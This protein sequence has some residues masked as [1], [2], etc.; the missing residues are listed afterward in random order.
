MMDMIEEE[1]VMYLLSMLDGMI[2]DEE[3]A[4]KPSKIRGFAVSIIALG[5]LREVLDARD[6]MEEDF[7]MAIVKTAYQLATRAQKLV[8]TK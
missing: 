3:S 4:A 1:S 8:P 2:S 5:A 7:R 6:L